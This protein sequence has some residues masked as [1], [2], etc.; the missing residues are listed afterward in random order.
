MDDREKPAVRPTPDEC[1]MASPTEAE[2]ALYD[3]PR[4][5]GRTELEG[6]PQ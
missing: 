4:R 3:P 1:P 5:T 2:G 6:P